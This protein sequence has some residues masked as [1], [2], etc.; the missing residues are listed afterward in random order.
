[1]YDAREPFEHEVE[2]RYGETDQMGVVY[3]ANYL[4]YF[5]DGRTRLMSRLGLSYAEVERRGFALAV[6]KANLRYRSPARYGETLVVRT[7]VEKLGGASVTFSYE[8]VRKSD[9][10]RVAEGSTE[11]ACIDIRSPERAV[12]MLPAEL[13]ASLE[14]PHP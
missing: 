2:V 8:I 6:R 10:E 1:V 4:L 14:S 11:L 13:R 5:E 12:C 7:W 9:R 3:H